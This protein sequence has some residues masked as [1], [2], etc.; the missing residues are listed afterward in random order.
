MKTFLNVSYITVIMFFTV[1]FMCS[2]GHNAVVASKGWGIDISWTGE[3]YIPNFRLGYWDSTS[4]VVKEN[5]DVEIASSAGLNASAN[6]SSMSNTATTAGGNAGTTIKLKTGP[7][8]NGYVKEVLTA[9]NINNNNVEMAKALYAVRSTME[10]KGVLSS[11]TPINSTTTANTDLNITIPVKQTEEKKPDVSEVKVKSQPVVE[12]PKTE[13]KTTEVITTSTSKKSISD[14]KRVVYGIIALIVVI[15][16]A[17]FVVRIFKKPEEEV[18]DQ[19]NITQQF[20]DSPTVKVD[21]QK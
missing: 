8:T 16:G 1:L 17:I 19:N 12:Q 20:N 15:I 5:V 10:S 14:F 3:S 21:Q 9:Q 11:S 18:V 7:Q 2:C 4:A 6:S 13:Q